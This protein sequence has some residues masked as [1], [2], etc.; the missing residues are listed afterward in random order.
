[1]GVPFGDERVAEVVLSVLAV[2]R[3]T[4][5]PAGVWAP[6]AA[7]ARRWL[8]AGFQLV[9]VG[10]DLGFLADGDERLVAEL[11]DSRR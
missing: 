1:M 3:E 11:S 9:I 7:V 5:R 8:D 6:S 4:G 2:A 10:S